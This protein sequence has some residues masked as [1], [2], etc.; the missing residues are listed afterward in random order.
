MRFVLCVLSVAAM[1]SVLLFGAQ[2]N[3]MTEE[4]Y[5][6]LHGRLLVLL[7]LEWKDRL[8]VAEAASRNDEE[9]WKKLE[10]VG[11]KFR[12]ARSSAYGDMSTTEEAFTRFSTENKEAIEEYLNEH[13]DL[14]GQLDAVNARVKALVQQFETVMQS[15]LQAS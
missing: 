3:A 11:T 1:S 4:G 8:A 14:R 13:P 5:C 9:F 2:S 15:R 7:E 10:E 6:N 12:S